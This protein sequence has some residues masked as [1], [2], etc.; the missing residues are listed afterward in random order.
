MAPLSDTPAALLLTCAVVADAYL[1]DMGT[2]RI[3][4]SMARDGALDVEQR[5]GDAGSIEPCDEAAL[6]APCWSDCPVALLVRFRQGMASHGRAVRVDLM[7][8][9]RAYAIWQ[10]ARA[11]STEDAQLRDLAAQLFNCLVH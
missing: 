2:A 6:E 11:R 5:F 8:Q 1:G 7:R 9:D 4:T 10:L 3:F